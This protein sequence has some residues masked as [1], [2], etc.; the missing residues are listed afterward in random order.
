MKTN[1]L[2]DKFLEQAISGNLR[3]SDYPKEWGALHL[4]VS[5]GMGV[6]ARVPWIAFTA[7]EMSVSNGYYP[8]FLYYKDLETLIL[9]YGVSDTFDY[10]ETWPLEIGSTYE[11]IK[12]HFDKNV[13]RYGDSFVFKAYKVD[14][15]GDSVKLSY[16]DNGKSV[17]DA[18]I[19][20]D[21]KQILDYYQNI[22][23]LEIKTVTT[24]LSQGIFYMEKQLED[25]IIHNWDYTDLGKELDL[26]VEEG[27]LKSQ[28]YRT[29]I[30]PMDILARDKK[31]GHYVVIELK[32]NQTSD[33]T[34][35]QLAR[36]MGWVK[37]FLKD[38]KVEG[39]IIA[40]DYDQ[41]LDLALSMV[42]DTRIYV[43]EVDFRLKELEK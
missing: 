20:S 12:A 10:G 27:V 9:S 26:I 17:S 8:V 31:D 19:D 28:Q 39:I 13:P 4:K 24:S 25:F 36:Y 34:V 37:K 7:P 40:K 42:P 35:G 30:G 2:L 11:T 22:T 29:D 18:D 33:D 5:F 38:D 15:N 16:E 14:T 1:E 32:R 21:L 3:T 6:A 43:Y 41:K 23:E